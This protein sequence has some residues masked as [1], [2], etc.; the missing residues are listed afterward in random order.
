MSGEEDEKEMELKDLIVQ[1]LEANGLLAKVKAQIRASV[2][3]ALDEN[4]RT[5]INAA[6]SSPSSSQSSTS[7]EN[8][9]IKQLLHTKDGKLAIS[10]IREFLEQCSLDFTLSVFE[11]ESNINISQIENKEKLAKILNL[12][13]EN[14]NSNRDEPLLVQLAR[15]ARENSAPTENGSFY[16]LTQIENCSDAKSVK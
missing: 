9:F 7:F 12:N 14:S 11:P 8:P 1:T 6:V 3:S 15:K 4:E 5:A 16:A 10:L 13:V 2:F